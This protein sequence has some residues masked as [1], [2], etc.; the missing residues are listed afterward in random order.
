MS[1]AHTPT[2]APAA[3][4]ASAGP[5]RVR[6]FISSPAD[7]QF[8]RMRVD[9]VVERLN[10]AFADLARLETVRWEREFY[11][12]HETFQ[13]QIPEAADCDIVIAVLRHRLGTELPAEFPRMADGEPYPSGTAYEILTAMEAAGQKGLP[14]IYVFRY[15]EPPVVK[16]DDAET[17]AL[18]TEQWNRLKGFFARWFRTPEGHFKASYHE[19]RSTDEFEQQVETLLRKWIEEKVLEGRSVVW[20][21][22]TKGSPFRGLSSFG[23]RHA[24]VFFGRG[25]DIARAVDLL[26]ESSSR[27]AAFLLLV[28]ASGSGKSSL[29]RA[30]IVPRL[31]TPGVVPGVDLWRVALYRPGEIR[32]DPAAGLAARLFE[33][34]G[35]ATD[36]DAGRP[37][38]LPELAAGDYPTPEAL[39]V[40]LGHGDETAPKPILAA[41]DKVA[42]AEQRAGGHARPLRADLVLVVDQIDNLFTGGVSPEERQR[43]AALLAAL[44]ATGRVWIVATLRADLYERFLKEPKLFDLKTAGATYDLQPPGPAELAEIVRGPAAAAD[45][46]FDADPSIGRTLDEVLLADAD[47]PDM[48]PLLQFTL[49]QLFERRETKGGRARLTFAAYTAIGG[50]GGAID[51]QAEVAVTA[52]GADEQARLPRLLRQLAEPDHDGGNAPLAIRA[53]PLSEAA[54]DEPSARLVDALVEARVLLSSTEGGATHVRLAHQRVLESWG[55]ARTI[56]A[57]NAGFFRVREDIE[58]QR[59]RWEES[60]RRTE[61][62]I[63][64]GLPLAE[65]ES[66]AGKFGAELPPGALAYVGASSR[67]ARARIRLLIVATVLFAVIA[68]VAVWQTFAAES[69][70]REA[71]AERDRAELNF[72]AAKTAVNNLAFDVMRGMARVAG[73]RLDDLR[74]I[75]DQTRTTIDQLATAAPADLDIGVARV[76]TLIQLAETLQALGDMDAGIDAA[77]DA[78]AGARRLLA[79]TDGDIIAERV[80]GVALS[81]Y[82]GAEIRAGN[83]AAALPPLDEALAI[84]RPYVSDRPEAELF[85]ADLVA[86]LDRLGSVHL[87]T[88]DGAAALAAFEESL[89]VSRTLAEG[90]PDETDYARN[91][92]V[93][94]NK[95]GDVH[96]AL[97]DVASATPLFEEALVRIKTL[98]ATQPSN[99]AWLLDTATTLNKV[100]AARLA[101]DDVDGA[102]AAFDEGVAISRQ[103]IAFDD[104]NA[105]YRRSL[106]LALNRAGDARFTT[107]AFA[108][109]LVLFDE[110]VSVTR[111][112]LERDRG[113]RTWREDLAA[114]LDRAAGARGLAGD[115]PGAIAEFEEAYAIAAALAAEVPDDFNKRSNLVIALYKLGLWASGERQAAAIAEGAAEV[116]R[117]AAEGWID[118][119]TAASWREQFADLAP[120]APAAP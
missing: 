66:V 10:G 76:S 35:A 7:A 27:G 45:L 30:G 4:G 11:R 63:P 36:E 71:T 15:P 73:V 120:A 94:L 5:R 19:F 58:D 113:N 47:R 21:I 46:D 88:G 96:S 65:A 44:A 24:A 17:N 67:R 1:I 110:A 72:T 50:M 28:G 95:V 74:P 90:N 108:A 57:E 59:R 56:V 78:V 43:F 104:A 38:A 9:R 119:A 37:A 114:S 29:A 68:V 52:L 92:V 87:A 82:A 3:T 112:L 2:S 18:I 31:T 111:G 48:L 118:A 26:K 80:L 103:L 23:A 84:I 39:A 109:A 32:G 106:A 89:A 117:L 40:L 62:L 6:I 13:A 77:A 12:A 102:M 20:P 22:E 14:D 53:V 91:L 41:L 8:E 107:G 100:G 101:S 60:G 54:F 85:R 69:R 34:A 33:G 51:R 55:R 93:A 98:S 83:Y 99:A 81:N 79:A 61:L 16:L 70:R 115:V 42:A 64:P 116:D 86:A 97:G 105:D 75:I 49:D 25:R